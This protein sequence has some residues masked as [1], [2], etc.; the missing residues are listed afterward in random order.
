MYYAGL[1]ENGTDTMISNEDQ[2]LQL[3]TGYRQV[4]LL[5]KVYYKANQKLDFELNIQ[6]SSS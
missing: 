3:N 6:Y 2:N 1:T 5:Q 4:N